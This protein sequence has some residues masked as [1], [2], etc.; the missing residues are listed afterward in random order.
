M[1]VG[2]TVLPLENPGASPSIL[3]DLLHTWLPWMVLW[4]TCEGIHQKVDIAGRVVN[5]GV[6]RMSGLVCSE[7][8]DSGIDASC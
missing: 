2:D 1:R 7:L 5:S 4:A 3:I 8:V 6:R